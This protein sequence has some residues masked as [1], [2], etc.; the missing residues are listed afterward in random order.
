[1]SRH[2]SEK[3]IINITKLNLVNIFVFD[4]LAPNICIYTP[5]TSISQLF[6]L[7]SASI[8][9]NRMVL[10]SSH[11]HTYFFTSSSLISPPLII[12]N[13]S[14]MFLSSRMLPV[15]LYFFSNSNA[16]GSIFFFLAPYSSAMSSKNFSVSKGISS[17][18]SFK[19]GTLMTIT[20]RR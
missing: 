13:R 7:N 10:C 9:Y 11:R 5:I 16:V 3:S 1:M 20:L 14:M 15:Q 8:P 6:F 17:F 4:V 2:N 19:A 18:R 12:T